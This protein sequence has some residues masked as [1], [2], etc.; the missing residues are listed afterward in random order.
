MLFFAK[1]IYV[2]PSLSLASCFKLY[3]G[4]RLCHYLD[5]YHLWQLA[6]LVF[7]IVVVVLW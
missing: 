7:G 4:R 6:T 5:A 1:S 2:L 3:C